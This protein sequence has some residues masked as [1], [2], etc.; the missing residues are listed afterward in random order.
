MVV[1]P[2]SGRQPRSSMMGVCLVWQKTVQLRECGHERE[3]CTLFIP[4]MIALRPVCT[5]ISST[6][7]SNPDIRV[8]YV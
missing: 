4:G 2:H 1:L 5:N 6:Q 8:M 3:H 7:P